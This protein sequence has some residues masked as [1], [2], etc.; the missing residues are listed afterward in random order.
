MRPDDDDFGQ[1]AIL[2]RN[3]FSGAERDEFVKTVAG[4]LSG[5]TG[6]VLYADA[7]YNVI[8]MLNLP[9]E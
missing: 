3:V 2:V 8:G 6:E 1:A 7:G 5:V 4:A 9:E